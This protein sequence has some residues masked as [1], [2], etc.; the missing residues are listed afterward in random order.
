MGYSTPSIYP[1]ETI[2]LALYPHNVNKFVLIASDFVWLWLYLN[3]EAQHPAL[4]D[5]SCALVGV[6]GELSA[7]RLHAGVLFFSNFAPWR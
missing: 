5:F 6:G 7:T 3:T 2:S 1:P 4:R